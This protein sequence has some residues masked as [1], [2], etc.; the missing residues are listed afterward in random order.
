MN[1][2]STYSGIL[3]GILAGVCWGFSGASGQFIFTHY[4]LDSNWLVPIRLFVSGVI[5]LVIVSF[6]KRDELIAITTN[7]LDFSRAI[8]AG[9][10]GT[11]MLQFTFFGAVQRSNA[12]TATVLQYLCPVITVIYVC[13]SSHKKPSVKEI[14]AILMALS[15][16]FFVSTHGSIHE[17]VMTP[18][19]ILWGLACAFSMFLA[20]I[21]PAPLYSKYSTEVVMS[22]GMLAGGM[23]LGLIYRPWQYEAHFDLPL[24]GSLFII[25]IGGSVLSYYFYGCAVK[26][27][28]PTK[29]T[30]I[31]SV[32]VVAAAVP[33][34]IFLG[35]QYAIIDIFGFMLIIGAVFELNIRRNYI[36]RYL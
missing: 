6:N 30:L 11:T 9:V 25:I 19:G 16:I 36:L 35:T 29:T 24:L 14:I 7:R 18:E 31:A 5:L 22:W 23:L 34:A 33:A 15:G 20:T 27:I 12:G 28:G 32:E 4:A 26:M 8:M 3:C 21:L 2:S 1:K 10:F 13:L 17:L